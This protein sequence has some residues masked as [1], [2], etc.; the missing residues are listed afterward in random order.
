MISPS[1]L[2][3]IIDTIPLAIDHTFLV[4]L[5]EKMQSSLLQKLRVSSTESARN[6]LSEDPLVHA[7][8]AELVAQR[9][10]LE[11]MRKELFEFGM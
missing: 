9:K 8:R 2:K 7:R 3:R 1:C 4:Y 6:Y 10:R 5:A 11:Q